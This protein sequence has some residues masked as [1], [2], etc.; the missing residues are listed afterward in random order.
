MTNQQIKQEQ[1]VDYTD[2]YD[3]L[4]GI[5]F[6]SIIDKIISIGDLDKNNVKILD[7]GCG[8]GKLKEKLG[9]KVVG[10][11][12][13]EEL[14]DVKDW[15]KVK[16]DVVVANEVFY[17]MT[18][19]E[20]INFLDKIYEMNPSA[21]LIIRISTHGIIN[22]IAAFFAGNLNPYKGTKSSPKVQL[23]LLENRMNIVDGTMVWFLCDIYVLEFKKEVYD[24]AD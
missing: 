15:R 11:D 12:I 7:F 17:L 4:K 1:A 5:Y 14:S 24:A 22:R 10:Y 19:K 21:K 9:K 6:N 2:T 8:V 23:I 20:I 16:F 3:G 18:P 13:V